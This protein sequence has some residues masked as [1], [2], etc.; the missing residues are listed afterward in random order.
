M[1]E[2]LLGSVIV[3][4]AAAMVVSVG[5]LVIA[6]RFGNL[7]RSLN[8]VCAELLGNLIRELKTINDLRAPVFNGSSAAGEEL[9]DQPTSLK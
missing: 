6:F 4:G 8:S 5:A 2:A 3:C 9:A 1:N 7:A